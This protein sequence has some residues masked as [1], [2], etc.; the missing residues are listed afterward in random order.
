MPD[1]NL[2]GENSFS[3]SL[4]HFMI[5]GG[6]KIFLRFC[7]LLNVN[8]S[9]TFVSSH[10]CKQEDCCDFDNNASVTLSNVLR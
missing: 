10:A 8:C 9:D 6:K 5:T 7:N 2:P 1:N 4:W 3:N